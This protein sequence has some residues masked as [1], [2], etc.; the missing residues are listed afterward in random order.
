MAGENIYR[1]VGELIS[2]KHKKLTDAQVFNS[3]EYKAFLKRKADNVITGTA[4]YLRKLGFDITRSEENSLIRSLIVESDYEPKDDT[5]A[6]TGDLPNSR[7]IIFVNTGN[8]LPMS[9][10]TREQKHMAILGLLYHEG[11]HLLFT[12]FPTRRAWRNQLEHGVWFPSAPEEATSTTEGVN[13]SIDM[14]DMQY[15]EILAELAGGIWNAIEDGFIERELKLMYPGRCS[16]CL[17]T[18][19]DSLYE[20]V[21][22]LD[23]IL[24]DKDSSNL[25]AIMSQILLYSKFEDL[26]LGSYSGELLNVIYDLMDIIDE[27]KCERE[28]RLRVAG[29]NRLLCKLQPYLDETI[30][31]MIKDIQQQQQQQ[32]Q[33]P[34]QSQGQQGQQGMPGGQGGSGQSGQ[35][36]QGG[37]GGNQSQNNQNGS[38]Q[39]NDGSN[40]TNSKDGKQKGGGVGPVNQPVP[41]EVVDKLKKALQDLAGKSGASSENNDCTSS[42]INNPDKAQNKNSATSSQNASTDESDGSGQQGGGAKGA[43][44]SLNRTNPNL[45]PAE[46]ELNSLIE[47][48]ITSK[49]TAQAEKERTSELNNEASSMTRVDGGNLSVHV[50]RASEVSDNNKQWYEEASKK[51]VPISRD[52]QRGIKDIL[53]DRR[54]GGVR[55]NLP[56]GPKFEVQSV[57][58]DDG[59]YFSRRKLPT[60][61]PRLGVGLL[62]DQSGSTSGELIQASLMASL[63]VEDFC[64]ELDIPHVICGYTTGSGARAQIFSYAEP[65]EIDNGNRYRI[66]GMQSMGGTPTAEALQYM[67]RRVNMLPVDVKLLIVISDGGSA[68][69]YEVDGGKTRLIDCIIN[70]AVKDHIIVFAAGIGSEREYVEKEFKKNFLDISNLDEMPVTFLELIRANLWV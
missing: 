38:Q 45:S 52:L 36:G 11:G 54:E 30:K 42:T 37:S 10:E 29:V 22:D 60:E 16:D 63:V 4:I 69:N 40:G 17:D 55:R 3:K 2:E 65:N 25:T 28:P 15:C 44:G 49:A 70:D 27:F 66:T 41:Q 34:Q 56:F 5:T 21:D 20:S 43:P 64:R 47:Q 31:D 14:K 59:K 26:K 53:K 7:H 12:D 50:D 68:D 57:V 8:D 58:H 46:K 62:V 1:R 61:T 18:I 39:S 13:L 19:N 33:N 23:V 35:S 9:Q 6:Y 48:I 32:Q 24:K 51:V 67:V